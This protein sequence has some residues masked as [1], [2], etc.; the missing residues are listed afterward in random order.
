MRHLPVLTRRMLK[1][2]LSTY[3]IKWLLSSQFSRPRVSVQRSIGSKKEAK[4][5]IKVVQLS[6]VG[7]NSTKNLW[8]LARNVTSCFRMGARYSWLYVFF[9]N[10]R[11]I[12]RVSW[13][14][15]PWPASLSVRSV[16]AIPTYIHPFLA[17][18]FV[19][20]TPQKHKNNCVS[21][22][23]SVMAVS[24]SGQVSRHVDRRSM[25][26]IIWSS[27]I[28]SSIG[29]GRRKVIDAITDSGWF[30]FYF[31]SSWGQLS[32]SLRTNERC[33]HSPFTWT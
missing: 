17:T 15:L 32:S 21:K 4:N 30:L 6:I 24:L 10:C 22:K 19:L 25:W 1:R 9:L 20:K 8:S 16:L 11:E 13:V 18:F 23:Y 26:L 14:L 29:N 5:Q 27:V 28:H 2:W 12:D 33:S 7:P 3:L 31:G